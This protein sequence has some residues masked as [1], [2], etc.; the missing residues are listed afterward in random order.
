MVFNLPE[1]IKRGG[2]EWFCLVVFSV[3]SAVWSFSKWFLAV[4]VVFKLPAG[5]NILR[6]VVFFG[7]DPTKW[8]NNE[9]KR[10]F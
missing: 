2:F 5:M 6:K 9:E 4:L 1:A 3:F 7:F 10:S 8:H